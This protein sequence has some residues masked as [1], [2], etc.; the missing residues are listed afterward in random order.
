VAER[1]VIRVDGRPVEATVGES[2][3]SA[4]LQAGHL[5][6]RT[7]CTGQA[8]APLC[9]MGTCYECQVRVNGAW[10]RACLEPVRADL[11]V[12]TDA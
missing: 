12:R 6:F 10:V 3:A 9:G 5:G 11:E 8:R 7:S 4:L 2:L 1:C